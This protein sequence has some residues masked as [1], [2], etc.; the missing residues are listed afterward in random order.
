MEQQLLTM[1]KN[2]PDLTKTLLE[3][4]KKASTPDTSAGDSENMKILPAKIAKK[5]LRQQLIGNKPLR[6][7]LKSWK[8]LQTSQ[9]MPMLLL[10]LTRLMKSI[11]TLVKSC[12]P[13]G[14]GTKGQL[15][16]SKHSG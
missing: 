16:P 5:P 14:Q 6:Q 1:L 8:T 11:L 12:C 2:N 15:M 9:I 10:L 4:L 3:S 13:K 7:A